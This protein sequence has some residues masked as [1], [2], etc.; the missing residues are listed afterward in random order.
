MATSPSPSANAPPSDAPF[1]AEVHPFEPL[2][3]LTRRRTLRTVQSTS[4]LPLLRGPSSLGPS[5][6]PSS[7]PFPVNPSS[8]SERFSE[9]LSGM[10]HRRSRSE[11]LEFGLEGLERQRT[12]SEAGEP[13]MGWG[14]R[15]VGGVVGRVGRAVGG[16]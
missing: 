7:I 12:V 6:R 4:S 9:T 16:S 2:P 1:S 10:R 13:G 8:S 15:V 3:N 5:Q 11:E 14:A